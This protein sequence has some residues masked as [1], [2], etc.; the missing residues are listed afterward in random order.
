MGNPT[1]SLSVTEAFEKALRIF[2]DVRLTPE[3]TVD[4]LLRAGF[5]P[6]LVRTHFPQV[7]PE[8]FASVTI[9]PRLRAAIFARSGG[10]RPTGPTMPPTALAV[11]SRAL[12]KIPAAPT[13]APAA[14]VAPPVEDF[15][16]GISFQ[17]VPLIQC[18]FPHADPGTQ[19]V[20]TRRNGW[21]E[22]TLSTARPETG[23]PYG[24]PARLLTIYCASEAI[25]TKSPEIYLGRSVHE[26]L[27]LLDVPITR[28]ERGSLRVYANQLLRLIHCALS[29][30][31]NI[32]DANGRAG[33]HIRQ[34]LFVEEARLWWDE[35]G[36]GQGSTLVL[37]PVLYDSIL[38][39]SAPLST[40]AIRQLRKSPMDLDVYAWL[41]HRLFALKRPS[42]ISW[43]QLSAQFGHDYAELRFFRRFFTDSLKRVLK[44][45]P[46]AKLNA[47]EGGVTLLPS[48]PHVPSDAVSAPR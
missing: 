33:L 24:V 37:S 13:P 3:R 40:K 17:Y 46:E 43:P 23:L 26:F 32:R 44:V 16:E 10:G 15:A 29:I 48:K 7:A 12:N 4:Q 30:D 14:A 34:A 18:S 27:R 45:Y 38:E 19:T 28:G 36:I 22:L 5:A 25:R 11:A 31:E 2:A 6:E 47:G 41:V 9:D 1:E 35:D 42:V 8:I 21:L 20:F 39:R